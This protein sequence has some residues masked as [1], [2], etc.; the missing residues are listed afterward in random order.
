[1][2]VPVGLIVM[3]GLFHNSICAGILV[4]RDVTSTVC[5]ERFSKCKEY[6]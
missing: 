4:N 3:F 2:L 1:V 6:C 5:S